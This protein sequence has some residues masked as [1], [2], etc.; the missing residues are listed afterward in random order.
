[1][2][3]ATNFSEDANVANGSIAQVSLDRPS[4]GVELQAKLVDCCS[5][6]IPVGVQWGVVNVSGCR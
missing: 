1:M 6:M 5:C 3:P 2:L 4:I